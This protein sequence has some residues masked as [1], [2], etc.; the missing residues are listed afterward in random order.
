[1]PSRPRNRLKASPIRA[2]AA[3]P[4]AA[5]VRAFSSALGP[6]AAATA[7]PNNRA[8]VVRLSGSSI[9]R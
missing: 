5:P 2:N 8:M 4:T 1:M 7:N 3:K 6:A 9:V